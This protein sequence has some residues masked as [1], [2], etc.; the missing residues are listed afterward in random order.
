MMI[1]EQ[2]IDEMAPGLYLFAGFGNVGAIVAEEGV[3][4]IDTGMVFDPGAALRPLR[5]L[6]DKPVKY[7]I[8]THG[9]ADH[10]ANAGPIL[11]EAA[12]RGDP[13][14]TIVA[15]A[16]VPR[17]MERYAE[18][19]EHNARINR[20]QFRVPAG[21]L[22]FPPDARFVRPD[23]T[24]QDAM[25][26]R[27]GELTLHL[28]HAMGETDDVTWIHIPERRAIFSGDLV[29]RS[30]PNIGNPLKPQR[31]EVE[32]AEALERML[33]LAPEVL[34]PGHGAVLRGEALA[35]ELRATA[36]ALRYLH[37]EVVR[38]LNA[39]EGEEQIVRELALPEELARHPAL[40]P[41]Y[42]SPHFI[43]QATVRRYTGWYDGNP[44]HLSP[45]PT[46]E[47][48]GE[49]AALAGAEALVVRAEALARAGRHQL[50]L[51]LLDFAL[52]GGRDVSI[53]RRAL[54]LKSASLARLAE[55]ET[56]FIA[57]SI[58]TNAAASAAEEASEPMPAQEPPKE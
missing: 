8:Y 12:E 39:G 38:R 49:V 37:D 7:I 57:R 13:R 36:R 27:L 21:A 11:A 29:L 48:A 51:H 45:A 6:T 28:F 42:G 43:V 2:P 31:F 56:S 35:D 9:H 30:C 32:W 17:R 33:A 22:S 3:A 10:A 23:L 25:T 54:A 55:A 16:N 19:Y 53:R 15:H 47:I 40:A 1:A 46:A 20:L 24:Y 4:L 52:D 5:S 34:G 26:L 58:L 14:P 50:A 44:S 18:L 41:V